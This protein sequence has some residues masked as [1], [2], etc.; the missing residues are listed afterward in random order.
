MQK[1]GSYTKWLLGAIFM[2]SGCTAGQHGS[3]IN[4]PAQEGDNLT[5]GV[6]QKEIR[7]GMSEGDVAGVLGSPNLVSRG[8]DGVDTWIYDKIS[9]SSASQSS[10]GGLFFVAG[11]AATASQNSEK[12]LTVVIKFKEGKVIDFSYRTTRF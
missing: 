5:L 7:V 8:K 2:L 1:T 4:L 11:A 6:V 3:T 9:S 10:A 12:T